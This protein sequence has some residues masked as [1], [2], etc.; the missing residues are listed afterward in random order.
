MEG[1]LNSQLFFLVGLLAWVGSG[2]L[3]PQPQ[4][5]KRPPKHPGVPP[6]SPLGRD[7][8]VVS[9]GIPRQEEFHRPGVSA[10]CD[11]NPNPDPFNPSTAVWGCPTPSRHPIRARTFFPFPKI[12][13]ARF[14][15][16]QDGRGASAGANH[17]PALLGMGEAP[18]DRE[19]RSRGHGTSQG[20]FP[21]ILRNSN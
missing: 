21:W 13:L 8:G 7:A 14:P 10:R 18:R 9:A 1:R 2:C 12:P 11:P 20:D 4:G 6:A 17:K 16:R 19:R 3:Q 15:G 5:M